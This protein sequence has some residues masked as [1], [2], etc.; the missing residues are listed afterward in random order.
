MLVLLLLACLP[1]AFTA[2][3][4]IRQDACGYLQT[5]LPSSTVASTDSTFY[6]LST[7][8]WSATAWGSP[9]CIVQPL[10]TA[11]VQ[12]AISYLSTQRVKFAIRS[13]GH[14]PSPFAANIDDGVLIDTSLLRTKEYNAKDKTVKIGTGLRWGEVYSYLDQYQVTVVGGRV[15]DVGVGG[16]ILGS[17]L[18]Y[19]SDLHGMAC[20]NVVNFEVVLAN[21]SA[22]DANA[23]HHKDL[24][25]VL[26]GGTN[27]FGLVTSFT[28]RT[29]PIY[30]VWGG[31]KMYS[32]EQIPALYKALAAYQTQPNKDPYAN[33]MLQ[34]FATNESLGAM[35]NMVY[36]KPEESPAAFNAFYDIPTVS[37]ATKL[38]TLNEMI[39]GQVVPSLPRWD[40]HSTSFTPSAEIYES[41]NSIV[42]TAPEVAQLKALTGGTL[43]LG[44]QPISSSL[45]QAGLERGGNIL[46]HSNVNQT[47]LVLDIGW[48][49]Q[50][51]DAIAHSATRALLQKIEKVTKSS[52]AYVRYIFMNDASW[53]QAVVNS[54][55]TNNVRYMRQVRER[56][57][58]SHTFYDLVSGGFKL[59]L[60]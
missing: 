45:V 38:Q 56:Y 25:R 42:S 6:D 27:N 19:L 52:A 41:I 22:V 12:K 60:S 13:G 55:G 10:S 3:I 32:H 24:F 9:L 21:G 1:L 20:D 11:D 4:R 23:T 40:W 47:W 35:L 28:L 7:E 8:N 33:L 37:D 53:D 30:N 26:K 58:P 29:Y 34:P 43:V 51:D 59:P 2:S 54:Y 15:L 5:L 31:V 50:E 46:G 49:R 14:S 18:S 44:F 36:L 16:L 39:S 17:G 57:D 48:W